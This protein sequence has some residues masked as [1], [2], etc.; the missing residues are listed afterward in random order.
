MGHRHSR[1]PLQST[2]C[3]DVSLGL[4]YIIPEHT[5][6]DAE[7]TAE[8]WVRNMAANTRSILRLRTCP[9][10]SVFP[11]TCRT[12]LVYIPVTVTVL[13]RGTHVYGTVF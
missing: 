13:C 5:G 6:D 1:Q 2:S 10:G 7:E 12:R 11:F 4:A 8:N 3:V 9:L